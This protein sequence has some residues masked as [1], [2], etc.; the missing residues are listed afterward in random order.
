[1]AIGWGCLLAAMD[2]QG[3]LALISACAALFIAAMT[4][5]RRRNLRRRKMEFAEAEAA[6]EKGLRDFRQ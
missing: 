4:E 6:Y 3:R 5:W 1:M 2:G